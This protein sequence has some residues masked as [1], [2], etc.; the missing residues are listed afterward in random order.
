MGK[1]FYPT[2]E[3]VKELL[4]IDDFRHLKKDQIIT[5]VSN[6]PKMD[7]EVA[8]KCIEQFPNF[9]DFSRDTLNKFSEICSENIKGYNKVSMENYMRI[10]DSLNDM[11]KTQDLT[12]EQ[13]QY[14]IEQIVDIGDKVEQLDRDKSAFTRNTQRILL[15][16]GGLGL[17]IAGSLFVNSNIDT[18]H[19]FDNHKPPTS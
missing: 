12:W 15:G 2:E 14:V 13:K 18:S 8:M 6:I 7:K 3:S 1:K 11:L 5:F 4:G 16:I 10:I 17:L 9:I 19:L